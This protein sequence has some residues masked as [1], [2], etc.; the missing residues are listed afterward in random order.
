MLTDKSRILKCLRSLGP[1]LSQRYG[2]KRPYTKAQVDSTF[3]AEKYN[4][5]YIR[6]AY[7]VYCDAQTIEREEI[8][9]QEIEKLSSIVGVAA[10]SGAAASF[11]IDSFFGFSDSGG[12]SFG[13][14]GGG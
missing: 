5:K 12:G 13:D 10:S 2:G 9:S 11:P 8:P 7:L 1:Q 3:D 6:Y 14:G 4:K